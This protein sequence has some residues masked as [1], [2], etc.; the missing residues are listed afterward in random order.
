MKFTLEHLEQGRSKYG[1]WSGRQLA[2]V[3]LNV[4]NLKKGW[5]SRLVGQDF[6]EHIIKEFVDLKNAHLVKNGICK[7]RFRKNWTDASGKW[8]VRFDPAIGEEAAV[9]LWERFLEAL[10]PEDEVEKAFRAATAGL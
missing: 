9:A 10:N 4:N 5:V 7:K 1:A 8:Q 6:P 3:G 2:L